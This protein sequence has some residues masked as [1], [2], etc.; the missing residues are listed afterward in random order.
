[1]LGSRVEL[2]SPQGVDCQR[3]GVIA[4]LQGRCPA[5]TYRS[6]TSRAGPAQALGY[7]SQLGASGRVPVAGS[8]AKP[9]S[10]PAG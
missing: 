3:L 1:M 7:G 5:S 4:Q 2:V 8:E 10:Q 9:G 6:T